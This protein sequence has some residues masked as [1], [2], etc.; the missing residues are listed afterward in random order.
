MGDVVLSQVLADKGLIPKDVL[1]RPD[2][3]ILAG[4]EQ[5]AERLPA[6]V[7]G[8]RQAGWHTRFSYKTTRNVGK[9]LKEAGQANARF[10]VI[11]DDAVAN[12]QC[13]V[14]NLDTG[15]QTEGIALEAIANHLSE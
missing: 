12:G 10:A 7:T 1:P 15:E 13:S 5:G 14:K 2:V 8:L 9:L 11:L 6:T 4:S 3:Y